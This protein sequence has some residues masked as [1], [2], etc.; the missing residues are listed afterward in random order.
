MIRQF[1]YPADANE[2][3]SEVLLDEPY[4]R[5]TEGGLTV[6]GGEP[7]VQWRFTR[8][9]L[10]LAKKHQIGTLVETAGAVS[11]RRLGAVVEYADIVYFDLKLASAKTHKR[12]VGTDNRL[13]LNNLRRTS[14]QSDRLV[15]RIPLIPGVNDTEEE[16]THLAKVIQS[17]PKV[18]RIGVLPYHRFGENK[19][20]LLNREYKMGN[21]REPSKESIAGACAVLSEAAGKE[22]CIGI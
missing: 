2:I 17:L 1:G 22:V 11:W 8:E 20:A 18:E 16:L 5:H 19:Y 7:A 6:S 15:V 12:F 4:Y 3:I 21:A 10:R 13:I 9:L 14:E